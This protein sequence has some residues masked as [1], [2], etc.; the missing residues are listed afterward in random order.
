V[1]SYLL[2]QEAYRAAARAL[3]RARALGLPDD[4]FRREALWR[5]GRAHLLAFELDQ[6]RETFTRLTSPAEPQAVRV[7]ALDWIERTDFW[8]RHGRDFGLGKT[9]PGKTTPNDTQ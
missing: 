4:R 7:E 6:A 1:G 9:T 5:L 3:R 2:T 8:A